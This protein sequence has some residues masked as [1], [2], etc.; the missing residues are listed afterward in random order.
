MQSRY[1]TT[2][3]IKEFLYRYIPQTKENKKGL[4]LLPSQTGSGKTH[5]TVQYMA[6]K[7]CN[8][9]KEIMIYIVNTKHNVE[10]TYHKLLDCLDEKNQKKVIFLKNNYDTILE[11]FEKHADKINNFKYI[12][13]IEEF[14]TLKQS[15][16]AILDS[17]NIRNNNSF[18]ATI[19]KDSSL[20]RRVLTNIYKCKKIEGY[21]EE[22]DE[23]REEVATLYPSINLY[24]YSAIFMTTHKFF[25]PIFQLKDSSPLYR[26]KKF[27]NAT[28]FI[29]EFDTQKKVIL[30]LIINNKNRNNYEFI[31]L[32][33]A[34]KNTLVTKQFAKK[35]YIEED[36]LE[37]IKTFFEKT[38]QK[39][40]MHYNFKHSFNETL[41]N[42]TILSDSTLSDIIQKDDKFTKIITFAEK[43]T[44]YI[45]DKGEL[46]FM[47][48]IRDINNGLKM[49][50]GLSRSVARKE[51]VRARERD[52][53]LIVSNEDDIEIVDRITHDLIKELGYRSGDIHYQYLSD[54]IKYNVFEPRNDFKSRED[55]LYED[56]FKL[57]N[58]NQKSQYS[59]N[60]DF[61]FLTLNN[62]PEKFIKDLCSHMFVVGISATATIF[63]LTRNFDIKYLRRKLADRFCTLNA[64]EIEQMDNLYIKA[65]KQ[66]NREIHVEYMQCVADL[67][68]FVKKYYAKNESI[69][70][71]LEGR[72]KIRKAFYFERYLRVIYVYRE[73]LIHKDI[74]SFIYLQSSYFKPNTPPEHSTGYVYLEELVRMIFEMLEG[75]IAIF[76][77]DVQEWIKSEL[78]DR[79]KRLDNSDFV[80]EIIEKN[81]LFYYYQSKPN[82]KENY[83]NFRDEKL[84]ANKKVFVLSGYQ[85]M[86]VGANM[87]YKDMDTDE[88]K[89][90]DAIGMDTPT[91]F[92]TQDLKKN[93]QNNQI[94]ALYELESLRNIGYFTKSE[95]RKSAK[96]ILTK[97]ESFVPYKKCTDYYNS[98]MSVVIQAVGRLYRTEGDNSK[99]FLFLSRE[100]ANSVKNFDS[101][102][103]SLLPAIKELIKHT[104]TLHIDDTIKDEELK[105]SKNTFHANNT[106]LEKKIRYMLQVFN[107]VGKHAD[108]VTEWEDYRKWLISN[109]TV[110]NEYTKYDFC[111]GK[112]PLSYSGNRSYWYRQDE[113]YKE[114]SVS[115]KHSE[116][117]PHVVSQESAM[118]DVI[119]NTKE[120]TECVT[121]HNIALEFKYDQ[122][123]TPIAFNNLYKGALGEAIGKFLIEK[124]AQINLIS[125]DITVEEYERFDY[126]TEDNSVYF[127]FKYYSQSTLET[128]TQKNIINKAKKK[129][130]FMGA[131]K[132]VIVNIF[133]TVEEYHNQKHILD[134]DVL[135][136]PFL[137]NIADRQNP[138]LQLS[139]LKTI[140]KFVS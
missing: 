109:P 121:K 51:V 13:Q 49:F 30:D 26:D 110:S 27:K 2:E 131:N 87:E 38:H 9:S 129:L 34:I 71:S 120:L 123:M 62:T 36:I 48:M 55:E 35:Y 50:I 133:A 31:D 134:E 40:N 37:S 20:L 8:D 85:V 106:Q 60:N 3:L 18:K 140:K 128:T 74:E 98:V 23:Y 119:K 96:E 118:L 16:E 5:A 70:D 113:D 57:I 78:I 6:D 19:E 32:F 7:I 58:I 89:D 21:H 116:E 12:S 69:L 72:K 28:I 92:L 99:M 103:Q 42:Q 22:I 117:H 93:R 67:P 56:G 102:K 43:Q 104:E 61:E 11:S 84:R 132:A 81:I 88:L 54:M 66:E 25:Y 52:R 130:E 101:S 122:I 83:K 139:M 41:E 29:D 138:E 4:F 135:L 79:R 94:K 124:F 91:G 44:N 77:K 75:S 114:I 137:I 15:V 24:K 126:K 46:S 80:K 53:D 100:I 76:E 82:N 115:F 65:K 63:T 97:T 17:K 107:G 111:Y 112:L 14:K 90:F 127:D 68:N 45:S 108:I 59:K 125:F 1:P 10:E 95:Y 86:G 136:I 33:T 39:Y 105:V 47:E 64:Q 73:F